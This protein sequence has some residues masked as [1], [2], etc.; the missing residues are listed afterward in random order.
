MPLAMILISTA[1]NPDSAEPRPDPSWN[2]RRHTD[3]VG[4]P[5]GST[6]TFAHDTLGQLTSAEEKTAAGAANASWTY[7]YDAAGNRLTRTL[8]GAG[9]AASADG[10]GLEPRSLGS[11]PTSGATCPRATRP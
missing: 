5:A 10:R 1:C 11:H 7:S 4:G 9:G 2:G 6:T 8:A 3:H